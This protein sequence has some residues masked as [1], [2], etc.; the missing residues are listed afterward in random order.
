MPTVL[1]TVY[2]FTTTLSSTRSPLGGKQNQPTMESIELDI[3]FYTPSPALQIHRSVNREFADYLE[4]LDDKAKELLEDANQVLKERL[5]ENRR[6]L[7]EMAEYRKRVEE[8]L[9]ERRIHI[10]Q[11]K[12]EKLRIRRELQGGLTDGQRRVLM[13]EILYAPSDDEGPGINN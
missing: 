2:C 9:E 10:A 11:E 6:V 13:E 12:I 8:A 4:D 1:S 3:T 7:V 5:V